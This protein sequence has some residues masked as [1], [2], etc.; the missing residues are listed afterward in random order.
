R[1]T[2]L[3]HVAAARD[4]HPRPV[5]GKTKRSTRPKKGEKAPKYDETAPRQQRPNPPVFQQALEGIAA[6]GRGGCHDPAYLNRAISNWQLATGS[7]KSPAWN[8]GW[9]WLWLR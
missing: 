6:S 8:L 9:R 4:A 1:R 2:H 5:K 7:A 3:Q